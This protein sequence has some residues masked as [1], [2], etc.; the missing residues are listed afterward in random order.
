[1]SRFPDDVSYTRDHLW[2][3]LN[4][5]RQVR[6]GVT[7]EWTRSL[8]TVVHA[9]LPPVGSEILRGDQVGQ[10]V[11][12]TESEPLVSPLSG[13]VAAINQPVCEQ[14]DLVRTDCYDGGW[15]FEVEVPEDF[16]RSTLELLDAAGYEELV[17]SG[18]PTDE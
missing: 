11:G 12:P 3:R 17:G 16:D 1:M 7:D 8:G 6:V 14:P 13:V 10:L 4:D 9:D 15:I 18:L 5:G 2:L